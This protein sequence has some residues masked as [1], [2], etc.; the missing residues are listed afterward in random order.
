MEDVHISL[1]VLN[2]L[3]NLFL[4]CSWLL[5]IITSSR[6]VVTLKIRFDFSGYENVHGFEIL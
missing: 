4:G 2:I 3:R 5:H 1:F 6:F